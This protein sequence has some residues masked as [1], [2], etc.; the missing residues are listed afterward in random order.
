[1]RDIVLAAIV[2]ESFGRDSFAPTL[3]LFCGKRRDRIKALFWEGDGF[4][5]LY[6]RHKN[7]SFK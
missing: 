2:Q 5:M 3:Y 7:G 4:V 1:M 6:M